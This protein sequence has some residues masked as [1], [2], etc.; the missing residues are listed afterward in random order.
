MSRDIHKL[1]AN[2]FVDANVLIGAFRGQKADFGALD[3][4][5]KLPQV[6]L[7]TS[8]LVVAQ[9]IATCQIKNDAERRQ[10][11]KSAVQAILRRFTIIS[12][13]GKDI[14]ESLNIEQP[15]ME[16]NLQYVMGNRM[17]CTHYITNNKRDFLFAN[18]TIIPAEK[19]R[20][21]GA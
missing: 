2:I 21:I 7:F 18:V 1:R 19:V 11:L 14:D 10:K 4:L 9:M 13:T 6:K 5:E 12:C 17:K 8:S 16:D 15:D 20:L 3:Y